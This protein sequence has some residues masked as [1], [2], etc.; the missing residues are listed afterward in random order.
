MNRPGSPETALCES[1]HPGVS[2]TSPIV[3]LLELDRRNERQQSAEDRS[4]CAFEE[5]EARSRRAGLWS[6]PDPV[7]PWDWRHGTAGGTVT[8]AD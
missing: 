8:K 1:R 7:P 6:E 3:R 5:R 2:F 4:A